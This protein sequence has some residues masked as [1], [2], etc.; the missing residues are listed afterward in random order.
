MSSK[1]PALCTSC[2]GVCALGLRS[3][4]LAEERLCG[5]DFRPR[6][7]RMLHHRHVLDPAWLCLPILA[8]LVR[9]TAQS[10]AIRAAGKPFGQQQTL[11][12]KS[13]ATLADLSG[14]GATLRAAGAQE[15]GRSA[16][17]SALRVID[18]VAKRLQDQELKRTFL[19]AI[20]VKALQEGEV[21]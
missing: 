12:P 4:T 21:G 13:A 20:P 17:A 19:T 14:A 1:Y 5:G 9:G 6:G 11:S 10:T 7:I 3:S 2:L 15:A 18:E 16:Y 8:H